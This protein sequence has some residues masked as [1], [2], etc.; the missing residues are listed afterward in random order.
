MQ[1]EGHGQSDPILEEQKRYADRV[2]TEFAGQELTSRFLSFDTSV[3][4]SI[5][6]EAERQQPVYLQN[7][8]EQAQRNLA[9]AV[10]TT[11][12]LDPRLVR[13]ETTE[14]I[15]SLKTALNELEVK[16][17]SFNNEPSATIAHSEKAVESYEFTEGAELGAEKLK[18]LYD[19]E[20]ELLEKYG[21]WLAYRD[22]QN[23][24]EDRPR[25]ALRSAII[26]NNLLPV[27]L[28][29]CELRAAQKLEEKGKVNP[30]AMYET[31]RNTIIA[32][33]NNL[34][35]ASSELK[36]GYPVMSPEF[37]GEDNLGADAFLFYLLCDNTTSVIHTRT[38]QVVED[39]NRVRFYTQKIVDAP[40]G[41]TVG[42]NTSA[43]GQYGARSLVTSEG[44]FG[45]SLSR[46][47]ERFPEV[48]REIA[49][50]QEAERTAGESQSLFA[51]SIVPHY[52]IKPED[53][54]KQ[55]VLIGQFRAMNE[56]RSLLVA[57]QLARV[58][59]LEHAME[60][61]KKIKSQ[62][63]EYAAVRE[64][65]AILQ[66][67]LAVVKGKEEYL[68]K[69]FG[70]LQRPRLLDFAGRRHFSEMQTE[71]ENVRRLYATTQQNAA[72]LEQLLGGYAALYR[73]ANDIL[74]RYGLYLTDT[75]DRIDQRFMKEKAELRTL[76]GLLAKEIN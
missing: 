44:P 15:E 41:H 30:L 64:K 37:S 49:L 25:R 60:I 20:K 75:L 31:I 62:E 10:Q 9:Q 57:E 63:K 68:A 26:K 29:S 5:K 36:N 38:K 13:P 42:R 51:E 11:E 34:N 53:R 50:I 7:Q 16:F 71:L 70:S 52:E 59:E 46:L 43:Y 45:G 1:N 67:E 72:G 65:L 54:D 8:I 35:R 61:L 73:E 6:G 58:T 39:E 40:P 55:E 74:D 56:R 21:P 28:L 66:R 24:C 76:E 14:Y 69:D 2:K 22:H 23:L 4:P 19:L 18:E 33:S 47:F 3:T 17:A 32:L 27:F 12:G 48:A